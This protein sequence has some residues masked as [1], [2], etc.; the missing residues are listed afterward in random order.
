MNITPMPIFYIRKH[1]WYKEIKKKFIKKNFWIRVAILWNF[2]GQL[3]LFNIELCIYCNGQ[4]GALTSPNTGKE[5][6]QEELLFT[7]VRMK[8]LEHFGMQFSNFLQN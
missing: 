8:N 1:P 6:E 3:F 5:V 2:I 7:E 4:T